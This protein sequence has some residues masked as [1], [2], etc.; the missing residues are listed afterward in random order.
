MKTKPDMKLAFVLL[1]GTVVLIGAGAA[2][3]YFISRSSAGNTSVRQRS[4]RNSG[5][6][7]WSSRIPSSL[8]FVLARL[9][10]CSLV[11]G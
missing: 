5:I 9:T 4:I 1:V 6:A 2:V 7:F 11:S 8:T 3:Q 10:C